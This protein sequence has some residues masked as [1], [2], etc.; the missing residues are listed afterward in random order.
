MYAALC[1][2]LLA[3]AAQP[4]LQQVLVG[5]VSDTKLDTSDAAVKFAVQAINTYHNK[6]GDSEPRTLVDIISAKSQMEMCKVEVWSRPWLSGDAAIQV[7]ND[8]KCKMMDMGSTMTPK[9]VGGSVAADVNSPE[10]TNALMFAADAVN[11]MSNDLY[12][13]MPVKVEEV[14]S[15]VREN[16]CLIL[17]LNF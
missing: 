8:P 13:R 10:V 1:V 6:L 11:K 2:T 17:F 12:Y 4:S 15:Q 5:G 16:Y 3:L 14:K 7:T 9:L